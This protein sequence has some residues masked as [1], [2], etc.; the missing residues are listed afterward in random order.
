MLPLSAF[1]PAPYLFLSFVF[2]SKTKISL[3]W[4]LCGDSQ[5]QAVTNVAGV[6]REVMMMKT[7]GSHKSM[8][9]EECFLRVF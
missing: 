9:A 6:Y 3:I 8:D 5:L 7:S 2:E 1:A 4:S